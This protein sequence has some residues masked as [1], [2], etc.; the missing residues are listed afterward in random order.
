MY[1]CVIIRKRLC[2]WA[3]HVSLGESP[4]SILAAGDSLYKLRHHFPA[5]PE[6]RRVCSAPV[7]GLD[8]GD[9]LRNPLVALADFCEY[10]L[11]VVHRL[12]LEL[13]LLK[14]R[15][16]Y[17]LET[18]TSL[19]VLRLP[20]M[21]PLH[22]GK[23]EENGCQTIGQLQTD[24]DEEGD[25]GHASVVRGGAHL[26]ENVGA[27]HDGANGQGQRALGEVVRRDPG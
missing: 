19:D 14:R 5:V 15:G 27:G 13:L 25:L 4:S 21:R 8:H 20:R 12:A 22:H 6:S 24:Q 11:E 7:T 17:P 10:V 9:L 1:N 16:D 18:E 2:Q 26:L 3:L 23:R